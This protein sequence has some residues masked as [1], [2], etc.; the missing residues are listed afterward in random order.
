MRLLIVSCFVVA[1][2][3]ALSTAS[4]SS[5]GGGGSSGSSSG[6]GGSSGSGAQ[7]SFSNDVLP[8]LV[9]ACAFT[10]CHNG[11]TS[12]LVMLGDKTDPM[13][14]DFAGQVYMN[15]VNKNTVEAPSMVFVKPNDP[16]NS[17]L[18]L[19]VTGQLSGATCMAN[20]MLIQTY[21]GQCSCNGNPCGGQMPEQQAALSSGD[22]DT[23]KNWISQ[24]AMQN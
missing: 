19:K 23:I 14:S 20:N 22:Q 18:Y 4:C 6:S 16:G 12:G 21:G 5:S 1:T 3:V 11:A 15:I 10:S 2:A 7:V 17:F 9:R 13:L 24:G 8:V